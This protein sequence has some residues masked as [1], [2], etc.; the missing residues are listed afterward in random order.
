MTPT[1]GDALTGLEIKRSSTSEQVAEAMRSMILRG[2]LTPGTPLKEVPLAESIGISRNTVREAVRVLARQGLV[3]HSMHRGAMVTRL[4]E[5][6]VGDL[7][8]VRRA[9]ETQAIDATAGAT[10]EQLEGLKAAVQDLERAAEDGDWDRMVD[11]DWRFHERL[12]GFLGSPRLDR[13]F[14]T[15]QAELRLCLSILDRD[16]DPE[17][18]VAEHRELRDLLLNGERERCRDILC[19]RLDDSERR[20]R[21]RAR[22]DWEENGAT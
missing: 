7:Y 20:L 8:R 12:V 16:D 13:F 18:L 15:V 19:A 14:D 22:S 9:L 21:E 4:S 17:D 11:A 10:A 3:T 5:D 2:E 1:S 6:D